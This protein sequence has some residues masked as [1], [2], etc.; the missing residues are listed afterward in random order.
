[1]ISENKTNWSIDGD[2][3]EDNIYLP[4]DQSDNFNYE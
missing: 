3:N 1:M 4:T 2:Y